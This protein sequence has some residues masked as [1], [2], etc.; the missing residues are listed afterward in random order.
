MGAIRSVAIVGAGKA[1]LQHAR[2]ATA[3]GLQVVAHTSRS[4]DSNGAK[5][6]GNEFPESKLCAIEELV[7]EVSADL[8]IVALPPE[9]THDVAPEFIRVSPH[10][11]L[12]K[13]AAL[14][15]SRIQELLRVEAKSESR[16]IV[17]YNR[18]S[19]PMVTRVREVLS[20]DPPT[21]VRVVVVEDMSHVR[22]TKSRV[23]QSSYLRH[24]SSTHF[25]DLVLFLFGQI[26]ILEIGVSRSRTEPSFLDYSIHAVNRSGVSINVTIDAGD[27]RRRGLDIT[28]VSGRRVQLSPLEQLSISRGVSNH[29]LSAAEP[30]L[31]DDCPTSYKDSFV[32]QLQRIV[33]DEFSALH[34]LSDSLMLS[35]LVDALEVFSR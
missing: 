19:Y 30:E 14:T 24:G 21:N 34:R 3:I 35:E 8:V 11:I 15:T 18:R 7:S 20:V 6:F 26:S 32:A 12:E 16:V 23:L 17:G 27:R 13:P 22:A 28:T 4:A 5:A 25:L 31:L 29:P 10:L 9:V 1:G 2:A 33:N